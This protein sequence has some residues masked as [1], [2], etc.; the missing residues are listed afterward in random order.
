MDKYGTDDDWSSITIVGSSSYK[1]WFGPTDCPADVADDDV[2]EASVWFQV[3]ALS[4]G[5]PEPNDRIIYVAGAP[6]VGTGAAMGTVG[7]GI[8]QLRQ[9]CYREPGEIREHFGDDFQGEPE[10]PLLD[11]DIFKIR[12][13]AAWHATFVNPKVPVPP[14]HMRRPRLR[15]DIDTLNYPTDIYLRLWKQIGPNTGFELEEVK[16]S[17]EDG[18][19]ANSDPDHPHPFVGYTH[20]PDT[21]YDGWDM[22]L[23]SLDPLLA[24]DEHTAEVGNDAFTAINSYFIGVSWEGNKAYDP[25]A[26][27]GDNATRYPGGIA[28]DTTGH[29]DEGGVYFIKI[30]IG[31]DTRDTA[32]PQILDYNEDPTTALDITTMLPL[33]G[34]AEVLGQGAGDYMF[35]SWDHVAWPLGCLG[36]TDWFKISSSALTVGDRIVAYLD[37]QTLGAEAGGNMALGVYTWDGNDENEPT[38]L[39]VHDD[40]DFFP[41]DPDSG[42]GYYDPRVAPIVK[43]VVDHYICVIG[44]GDAD[45]FTAPGDMWYSANG[46]VD[47]LPVFEWNPNPELWGPVHNGEFYPGMVDQNIGGWGNYELFVTLE[48]GPPVMVSDPNGHNHWEPNDSMVQAMANAFVPDQINGGLLQG[49]P[50]GVRTAEYDSEKDPAIR[51]EPSSTEFPAGGQGITLGDGY[52]GET[53]EGPAG[54]DNGGD[55]DLYA[56][57]ADAG[58]LVYFDPDAGSSAT[59]D[60]S[61]NVQHNRYLHNYGLLLSDEGH[62]VATPGLFIGNNRSGANCT[63]FD[64]ISGIVTTVAPYDGTYYAIVVGQD[65][66][67]PTVTADTPY[68]FEKEGTV[69]AGYLVTGPG[70]G[71]CRQSAPYGMYDLVIRLSV[72]PPCPEPGALLFYVNRQGS[73]AGELWDVDPTDFTVKHNYNTP[74]AT[75]S[76]PV[77]TRACVAIS[78]DVDIRVS[79]PITEGSGVCDD[80]DDT[81]EGLDS[82]GP[83]HPDGPD[84]PW[85]VAP[86]CSWIDSDVYDGTDTHLVLYYQMSVNSNQPL[87]G[88]DG[89]GDLNRDDD[90]AE[91]KIFM[92]YPSSGSPNLPVLGTFTYDPV[93]WAETALGLTPP[94]A[95]DWATGTYHG[96][97]TAVAIDES[98]VDGGDGTTTIVIDPDDVENTGWSAGETI[99]WAGPDGEL[100]T[101]LD[102]GDDSIVREEVEYLYVMDVSTFD[103]DQQLFSTGDRFWSRVICKVERETGYIVNCWR[104][105]DQL[106]IQHAAEPD[107]QIVDDDADG[108]VFRGALGSALL[109]DWNGVGEHQPALVLA[110]DDVP[111]SLIF[112]DP[113][114][115]LEIGPK[116]AS[117]AADSRILLPDENDNL[118]G[119]TS[120]TARNLECRQPC[121]NTCDPPSA[122]CTP[123]DN[124]DI[125]YVGKTNNG[126]DIVFNADAPTAE[127]IVP[128]AAQAGGLVTGGLCVGYAG[129]NLPDYDCDTVVDAIDNCPREP[130]PEQLDQDN[131]AVGDACSERLCIGDDYWEVKRDDNSAYFS[132]FSFADTAINDPLPADFFGPGSDPFDGVIYFTGSP[133]MEDEA[134]YEPDSSLH[135]IVRRAGHG[136]IPTSTSGPAPSGPALPP[137]SSVIT[138]QIV[139]MN[140]VSTAPIT[141]TGMAG[142]PTTWDVAV[143]AHTYWTGGD[144]GMTITRGNADGGTYAALSAVAWTFTFTNTENS[145]DVVTV[146]QVGLP[147]DNPTGGD[148]IRLLTNNGAWVDGAALEAAVGSQPELAAVYEQ[149]FWASCD[150][151]GWDTEESN[152]FVAGIQESGG[153]LSLVT[154]QLTEEDAGAK[155]P[156]NR[157]KFAVR[158][159]QDDAD[160]DQVGDFDDNCLGLANPKQSDCDMD[161]EGDGCDGDDPDTDGD[162]VS[163]ACEDCDLEPAL[164]TPSETPEETCDDGIDNDCDGDTDTDDPD[165]VTGCICGDIDVNPGTTNLGDFSQFQLCF[166]LRAPTGQCPQA[167]FDCCDLNADDWVNLTDFSTFQLLFGNI[168]TNSVPNCP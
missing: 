133:V 28:P 84:H 165:C 59:L 103:Q 17:S 97:E 166:G 60:V 34:Y 6:P 147:G 29:E 167:L 15:V 47:V 42:V 99:C 25:M 121:P 152:Y 107:L 18:R 75:F 61:G 62:I 14:G 157:A 106:N 143:E 54:V 10:H 120:L 19:F 76:W 24:Y 74:N 31:H 13:F 22:R 126:L 94:T 127:R 8:G 118:S 9:S 101:V 52:F 58:N 78:A 141:V 77:V 5:P 116:A 12:L 95:N 153:T 132:R 100:Q 154:D 148:W 139:A 50:T 66:R 39:G 82:G 33:S 98:I 142:G 144:L 96:M 36:D 131:D 124:H 149:E 51:G 72:S 63:G 104:F 43:E 38:L 69:L 163:D 65:T 109:R 7:T 93:T 79:M 90:E 113:T 105:V 35:D 44:V 164:L 125:I 1:I 137:V 110:P 135:M 80:D 57:E 53:I 112:L 46:F 86:E 114:T 130:N 108:G 81:S 122:E 162:L 83:I 158:I 156:K 155:A 3:W 16:N 151:T 138:T 134:P 111:Y 20:S 40:Q 146:D 73:Q 64:N 41:P 4:I 117:G 32:P 119:L 26:D 123:V 21:M 37:S 91:E 67:S 161:G 92:L 49:V 159:A 102:G 68:D 55:V 23:M 89:H 48:A 70:T 27:P 140:L 85:S 11:V 145:L 150:N 168:S 160:G 87:P 56:F 2:P 45:D 128:G 30:A 71:Q 136:F 115:L 129:I 88:P